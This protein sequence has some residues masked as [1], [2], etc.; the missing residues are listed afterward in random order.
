MKAVPSMIG[1]AFYDERPA[2]TVIRKTSDAAPT[3]GDHRN[4]ARGMPRDT[5][6]PQTETEGGRQG[7]GR[8][9]ALDCRQPESIFFLRRP[10]GV[11]T[12]AV[13]VRPDGARRLRATKVPGVQAAEKHRCDQ[14]S[15]PAGWR[16]A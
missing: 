16:A 12:G 4:S 2:L 13:R 9:C 11:A 8:T 14:E 10:S 3:S 7:C 6:S 1:A 15:F 5:F